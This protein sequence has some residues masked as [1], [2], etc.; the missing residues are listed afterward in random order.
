MATNV[1][2]Q[3]RIADILKALRM[4]TP[5]VEGTAII[6]AEGLPVASSLAADVE[7]DRISAMAAAM[8]SLGDRTSS[9]LARGELEQVYV[10]GREGYVLLN[11]VGRDAVLMVLTRANAKLGM[12]FLDA[13]RAAEELAK[14]I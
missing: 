14:L 9:E 1:G 2:R 10:K 8:L 11:H 13:R 3:Q 5:D 4:E 7:E 6:T 12:I